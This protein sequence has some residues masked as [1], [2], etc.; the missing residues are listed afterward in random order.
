M[1]I[2][3]HVE[4]GLTDDCHFITVP[5]CPDKVNNA[6]VLP[7][8]M[9]GPPATDPATVVGS[10]VIVE[11]TEFAA[12]QLPLLTTALNCVVAVKAPDV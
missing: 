4:N 1:A 11:T 6:L 12:A 10:R 3:V 5:V 7:E 8:Q 2:S 9:V